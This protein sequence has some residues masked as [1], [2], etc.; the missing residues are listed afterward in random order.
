MTGSDAF[1]S[2]RRFNRILL[3]LVTIG[4]GVAVWFYVRASAADP[5]MVGFI[6]ACGV[7]WL[8]SGWLARG[9]L[10]PMPSTVERGLVVG[11]AVA[12][13]AS[14]GLGWFLA[15][16]SLVDAREPPSNGSIARSY[17]VV[18]GVVAAVCAVPGMVVGSVLGLAVQ[19][20]A[21]H[22]MRQARV[23]SKSSVA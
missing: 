1:E 6:P 18:V 7:A 14:V 12:A 5:M 22:V 13:V 2:V 10:R 19:A 16:W 21:D 17:L 8:L 23:G 9:A 4:V 3:L 15:G 20:R 11:A